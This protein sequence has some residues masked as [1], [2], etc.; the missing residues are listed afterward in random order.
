MRRFLHRVVAYVFKRVCQHIINSG[1]W[2]RL[3]S[4]RAVY[5]ASI[6]LM[7]GIGHSLGS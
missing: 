1:K 5:L 2:H 6:N 7:Y 4:Q 3:S